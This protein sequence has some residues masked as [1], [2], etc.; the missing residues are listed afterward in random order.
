MS[1]CLFACTTGDNVSFTY[2]ADGSLPAEPLNKCVYIGGVQTA[3][4][5]SPCDHRR[6]YICEHMRTIGTINYVRLRVIVTV[7]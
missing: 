4:I 6:R 2:W 5:A 3:W 1:S 7:L